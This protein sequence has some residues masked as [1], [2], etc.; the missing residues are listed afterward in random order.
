M[1]STSILFHRVIAD[2]IQLLGMLG[3]SLG[4]I[5]LFLYRRTM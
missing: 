1:V 2:I 3:T 5:F 4:R